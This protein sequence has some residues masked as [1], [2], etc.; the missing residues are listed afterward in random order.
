MSD[1]RSRASTLRTIFAVVGFLFLA[2][3]IT[4]FAMDWLS[5]SDDNGTTR[6]EIDRTEIEHDAS[7]AMEKTEDAYNDLTDG[8]TQPVETDTEEVDVD[9][10]VDTK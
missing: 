9:V 6:I 2:F 7:D 3:V 10:D 5:V 8:T 1:M 4:A